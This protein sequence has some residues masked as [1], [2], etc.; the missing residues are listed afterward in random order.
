M[1]VGRLQT[2]SQAWS[3]PSPDLSAVTVGPRPIPGPSLSHRPTPASGTVSDRFET[4]SPHRF[5][6][7]WVPD[8][9]HGYRSVQDTSLD[10]CLSHRSTLPTPTPGTG[11]GRGRSSRTRTPLTVVAPVSG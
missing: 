7:R 5:K 1:V 3:N 10:L 4:P 8:P 2:Q 6:S 11:V 9:I